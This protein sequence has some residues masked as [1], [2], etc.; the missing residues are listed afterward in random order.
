MLLDGAA[1]RSGSPHIL[2]G[3]VTE[4]TGTR[5]QSVGMEADDP[6]WRRLRWKRLLIRLPPVVALGAVS[7]R[8]GGSMGEW[9][10]AVVLAGFVVVA[11]LVYFRW[12]KGPGW[13]RDAGALR[14]K[15]TPKP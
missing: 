15:Q 10:T 6:W 8:E 3:W 1:E 4:A 14:A 13:W 2:H 5:C 12:K 7:L 9:F 11:V